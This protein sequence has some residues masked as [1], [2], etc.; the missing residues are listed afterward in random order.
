MGNQGHLA[1]GRAQAQQA[2][3]LQITGLP[4]AQAFSQYAGAT[5]SGAPTVGTFRVGQWVVDQTGSIRVCT[6]AGSPGTWAEIGGGGTLDGAFSLTGVITPA[7]FSSQQNDYNPTGLATA[8][9]VRVEGTGGIQT[10]TGLA[11]QSAGRV[12]FV[13][14]VGS[15]GITFVHESTA[16][17][18]ANRFSFPWGGRGE[19]PGDEWVLTV[20][21]VLLLRYD[22]TLSRWIVQPGF[23]SHSHQYDLEGNQLYPNDVEAAVR[24]VTTGEFRLAGI[25]TPAQITADQNDYNP[26]NNKSVYRLSSDASRTITG[27]DN[28][29]DFFP[30]QVVLL[31]NVGANPIVLADEDAGSAAAN[32][33]ALDGNLTLG[34]DTMATVWYDNTSSRWRLLGVGKAAVV[35]GSAVATDTIFDAKGDIVAATGAD[36]AARVAVG[37]NNTLLT[38]DSSQAS[39]VKWTA[40]PVVASLEVTGGPLKLSGDISPAQ[41]T[42]DQNDYNPTGLS[43]AAVLRLTSDAS[44]NITGLQGGADGRQLYVANV[45]SNNIVLNDE[46]ASSSAANRFA[47]DGDLTLGADTAATLLYDS[48]SSRWRLLGVGKTAGGSVAT[49]TIWDAAGDLAVGTGANTAA[50]KAMGTALQGLRVNSGAT[51]LEWA[52]PWLYTAYLCYQDQKAQNTHGGTFTTGA[53]RTRDIN[54]EVADPGNNGTL[55]SNQITLAAGTYRCFIVCPG[56]FVTGHQARLQNVTDATTLLTG[57][58]ALSNNVNG[59]MTVSIIVGRFTVAASKALEIQHRGNATSTNNGF[60]QAVNLTTEVYTIAEFWKEA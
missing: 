20:N 49:D 9:I 54:T 45:G 58:S 10:V 21:S 43:T 52:N 14:N 28:A 26:G 47:L 35:S 42:A 59:D 15:L 57:T 29:Q 12:L 50:K 16:S 31:V 1:S 4:G 46:S 24:L 22:G 55:A 2:R 39:G 34:A 17:A 19:V 41:I 13:Q 30:N 51:D 3:A 36:A 53:W 8:S 56:Y 40:D 7:S 25:V 27:F 11:A 44:R 48:T 32:R 5:V 37:A 6:T 60:G 23:Q 38:A 18:A 33:F